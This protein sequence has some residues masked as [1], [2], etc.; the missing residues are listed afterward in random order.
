MGF[1]GYSWNAAGLKEGE[2]IER[3]F[4]GQAGRKF[5]GELVYLPYKNAM[6]EVMKNQPEKLPFFT[7]RI[8]NTVEE[9]YPGLAGRLQF[10]TA[11]GTAFDVYHGVDAFFKLQGHVVTLDVTS[12]SSKEHAKADIVVQT[13]YD[14]DGGIDF[15]EDQIRLLA[16]QVGQVFIRKIKS[17]MH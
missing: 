5:N 4:F 15:S 9:M 11:V 14:E 17:K 2:D 1:E 3:G 12:N 8:I 16:K 6:E 10:Y 7:Q 13:G